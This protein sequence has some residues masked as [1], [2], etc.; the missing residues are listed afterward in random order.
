MLEF[1]IAEAP[2]GAEAFSLLLKTPFDLLI[3]DLK[4]SP[5]DGAQLILALQ[6]FPPERRPKIIVCSSDFG[7]PTQSE[8]E[9]LQKADWLLTK[10]FAAADLIAAVKAALAI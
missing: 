1:E 4:M 6:I 2:N 3:T 8:R 10:P 7:A 9:A 5:I